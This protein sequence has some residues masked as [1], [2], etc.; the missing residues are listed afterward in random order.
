MNGRN[1]DSDN[2]KNERKKTIIECI[3]ILIVLLWSRFENKSLI[4][5]PDLSGW[6]SS[7]VQSNKIYFY[8]LLKTNLYAN[9]SFFLELHM[10]LDCQNIAWTFKIE[11][12]KIMRVRCAYVLC[13]VHALSRI[14]FSSLPKLFVFLV[15]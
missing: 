4:F 15:I 8:H 2:G 10:Q 3:I 1:Q 14:F 6:H 5:P 12:I 11:N 9:F 7:R 13:T